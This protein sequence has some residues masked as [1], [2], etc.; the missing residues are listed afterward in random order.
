MSGGSGSDFT[1]IPVRN[2]RSLL[3]A[4]RLDF[5]KWIQDT[6]PSY[7]CRYPGDPLSNKKVLWDSF[8]EPIQ[9]FFKTKKLN[10]CE[11][12]DLFY[13]SQRHTVAVSYVWSATDLSRIAGELI[14]WPKLQ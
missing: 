2:L 1:S 6:N 12:Y 8:S 5:D 7:V 10:P 11:E 3:L 13:S 4:I 14:S 9:Y